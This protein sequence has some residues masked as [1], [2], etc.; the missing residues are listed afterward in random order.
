MKRIVILTLLSQIFSFPLLSQNVDIPDTAFLNILI[1]LGIDTNNDSLI[2]FDEAKAVTSLDVSGAVDSSYDDEIPLLIGS[3]WIRDLTGIE[4]FMNLKS[5]D[6]SGN[7]LTAIDV[8]K[9]VF[10]EELNCSVHFRLGQSIDSLDISSN[11]ELKSLNCCF[12]KISSLD[13]T[14]NPLLESL[15]CSSTRLMSLDISNN[16]MITNLRCGFTQIFSLDLSNQNELEYLDCDLDDLKDLDISNNSK[17]VHLRCSRNRLLN[18]DVSKCPDLS[19]LDCHDN[20]IVN[21]EVDNNNLLTYL[22]CRKNNISSLDIASNIFLEF[23]SCT[24]NALKNIDVS[25]N[26]QLAHLYCYGNQL[27]SL[28]ISNNTYLRNL[29]CG[30][31]QLSS[32]DV[33]SNT[34]LDTLQCAWYNPLS[35]LSL[36]NNTLLKWLNILFLPALDTVYVWES[37]T[38]SVYI[39][40]NHDVIFQ[41]KCVV[42]Y[43]AYQDLEQMIYPNPTKSY[44]TVELNSPNNTCI[45][46]TSLSGEIL[47]K[48]ITEGTTTQ[49]DLSQLSKGVYIIRIRSKDNITAERIIKL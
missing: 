32:L 31:N 14:N 23:L 15:D 24:G 42:G 5:L 8:S 13:L 39:S 29:D 3:G 1:E 36:C 44:I 49:L 21:M 12:T 27:S 45:E 48:V 18:L 43:D 33:S 7:K 11:S 37:F 30:G 4:A 2:S 16:P 10:L 38:D 35:S 25:N 26:I 40:S 41:E 17:L 46:I 34:Q 19:Y 20:D 22:D 6:C 9:N 47:S 28:D